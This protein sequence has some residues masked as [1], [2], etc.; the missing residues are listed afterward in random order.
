MS[1]SS[2]QN[3]ELFNS[4]KINNLLL[5]KQQNNYSSASSISEKNNFNNKSTIK[6]STSDSD[7][8]YIGT[9]NITRNITT[10]NA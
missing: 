9:D 7:C 4:L 3:S 2:D 5:S 10:K 8:L 6:S 1:M